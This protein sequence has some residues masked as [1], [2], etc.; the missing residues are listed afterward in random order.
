M[1]TAGAAGAMEP[2]EPSPTTDLGEE[3]AAV[4]AEVVVA[5]VVEVALALTQ[6]HF[7]L[8]NEGKTRYYHEHRSKRHKHPQRK[9]QHPPCP[10]LSMSSPPLYW[11]KHFLDHSPKYF[12]VLTR[13]ETTLRKKLV[14]SSIN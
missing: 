2:Q 11:P 3:A 10:L 12:S 8:Q 9:S 14:F 6:D 4:V 1:P 7:A 13:E 5:A